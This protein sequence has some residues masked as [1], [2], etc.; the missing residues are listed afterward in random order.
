MPVRK[1]AETPALLIAFIYGKSLNRACFSAC[2]QS[3]LHQKI[4]DNPVQRYDQLIKKAQVEETD[5]E[6]NAVTFKTHISIPHFRREEPSDHL[7]AV[8]GGDRHQIKECEDDVDG[9]AVLK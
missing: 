4:K 3:C 2:Q 8:K 9:A 7:G 1:R 6:E 5:D